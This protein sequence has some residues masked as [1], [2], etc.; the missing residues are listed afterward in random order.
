MYPAQSD[1]VADKAETF[2]N[3]KSFF[4]VTPLCEQVLTSIFSCKIEKKHLTLKLE[5]MI[6]QVQQW[7]GIFTHPRESY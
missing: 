7:D 5:H 1:K 6:S 2:C 4:I 3:G